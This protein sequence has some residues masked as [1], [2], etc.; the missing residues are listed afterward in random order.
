MVSPY[1]DLDNNI[2]AFIKGSRN[3]LV[4]RVKLYC[5]KN[6]RYVPVKNNVKE[7]AN[8]KPIQHIAGTTL[9]SQ[10]RAWYMALDL[11]K[12]NCVL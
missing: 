2:K 5:D 8:N 12:K 3:K 6:R 10:G 1:T 7:N 4:S 11:C 9:V